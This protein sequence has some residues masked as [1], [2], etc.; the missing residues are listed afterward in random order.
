[1]IAAAYPCS[2]I[3]SPHHRCAQ[4]C[5]PFINGHDRHVLNNRRCHQQSVK[6]FAKENVCSLTSL[7]HAPRAEV[8]ALAR[9]EAR[10]ANTARGV[11]PSRHRIRS[12]AFQGEACLPERKLGLRSK[13]CAP[14]F[15][16]QSQKATCFSL[17]A[18]SQMPQPDQSRC[19]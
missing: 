3:F 1:M 12:E 14:Q 2:S 7:S 17:I 10:A 18:P 15:R 4:I 16:F 19:L 13:S 11:N 6:R 5:Y 8:R 9:F